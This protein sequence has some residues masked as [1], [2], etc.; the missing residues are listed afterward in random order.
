MS[1]MLPRTPR[2][3]AEVS[4]AQ[5]WGQPFTPLLAQWPNVGIGEV[6]V[7]PIPGGEQRR[8]RVQACLRLGELLPLDVNVDLLDGKPPGCRCRMFS[9]QPFSHGVFLYEA[10]LLE[11]ELGRKGCEIRVSPA[12]RA[13]VVTFAPPVVRQ[14]PLAGGRQPG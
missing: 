1:N 6:T 11:S 13:S 5:R 3:P 9:V 7:E 12:T 4:P 8:L 2:P 14:I 10:T